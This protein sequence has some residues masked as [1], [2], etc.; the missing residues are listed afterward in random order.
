MDIEKDIENGGAKN[1]EDDDDDED[2]EMEEE[3]VESIAGRRSDVNFNV[4]QV[5]AVKKDISC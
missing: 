2:A 1:E 4:S 3:E 5:N